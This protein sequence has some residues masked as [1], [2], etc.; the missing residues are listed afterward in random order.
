MN[1]INSKD[2][3]QIFDLA[4]S[5]DLATGEIE[6]H[7]KVT[8]SSI[9][10]RP[11][12]VPLLI[13]L[14]NNRPKIDF[15]IDEVVDITDQVDDDITPVFNPYTTDEYPRE[16]L[17]LLITLGNSS[18]SCA[19]YMPGYGPKDGGRGLIESRIGKT[20][21]SLGVFMTNF[22]IAGE[23]HL[24]VKQKMILADQSGNDA[25]TT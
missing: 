18:W 2:G 12:E 24:M 15:K 9:T 8:E 25:V 10:L 17:S 14:L 11:E 6:I 16:G 7:S 5:V 22:I 20:Y 13:S 1:S 4:V 19:M 21:A 3:N 23:D